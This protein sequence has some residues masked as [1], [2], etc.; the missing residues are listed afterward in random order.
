MFLIA[1]MEGD[2]VLI[3]NTTL[4]QIAAD[5]S[6]QTTKEVDWRRCRDFFLC[7][8]IPFISHEHNL[9]KVCKV[10]IEVTLQHVTIGV[11]AKIV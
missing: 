7:M 8:T 3:L 10:W 4:I 2:C 11:V 6:E 9:D 5:Y 1:A